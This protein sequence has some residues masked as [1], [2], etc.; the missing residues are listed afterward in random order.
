MSQLQELIKKLDI[1]EISPMSYIGKNMDIGSP[2]I[3]GGHVVA[4]AIVAAYRSV[5]AP[6]YLH[7]LHS[8]FL[9]PGNNLLDIEYEVEVVKNGRSFD[10]RRVYARQKDRIIFLLAASFH[11][12]EKGVQHQALM[13]N[14]TSPEKL[15]SFPEMFSE[16]AAKFNIKPKGIFSDESP[17]IFHPGDHYNPFNPGK[18]PARNHTWFKANGMAPKDP[19]SQLALL[20]YASDFN[21]LVTSLMP[22]DISLFTTNMRIASLDH[23]MW[24]HR[25]P[26]L[27]EW[28]LYTVESPNS[29]NARGFCQGRIFTRDG[30]LIASVAQEGLIRKID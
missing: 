27:N 11:I 17:I 19:E 22:H 14:V 15:N 26:N 4:Q 3:Y 10:V 30:T 18:R 1:N 23:A 16:F 20:A 21:L 6:K 5:E 9:H 12:P 28:L 24:I 29:G 13:P 8:Y 7:S 2:Q 25:Q